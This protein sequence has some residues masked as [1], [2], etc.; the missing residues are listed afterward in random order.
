MDCTVNG[1]KANRDASPGFL[2]EAD[3]YSPSLLME[4]YKHWWQFNQWKKC[5]LEILRRY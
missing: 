5:W 1:R 4:A 3:L 2:G